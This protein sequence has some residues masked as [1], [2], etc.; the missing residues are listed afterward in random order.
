M[1]LMKNTKTKIVSTVALATLLLAGCG[2]KQQAKM[3]LQNIPN[4]PTSSATG[5]VE[6]SS[7]DAVTGQ[8]NYS[9]TGSYV[10]PEGTEQIGIEL[11]VKDGVVTNG[12][13]TVMARDRQSVRFQQD[14]A[15]NFTPAVVGKKLSE[16]SA[17]KISG[18]S[19]T[20]QG[21][22]DALDKI[23]QQAGV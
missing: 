3:T 10:T 16:L 19:L 7:A 6:I 2:T 21:F 23:K 8:K 17:T 14:F 18:G 1:K 11:T 9:A 5:A 22:M 20:P 4:K 12:K 13:A 15:D